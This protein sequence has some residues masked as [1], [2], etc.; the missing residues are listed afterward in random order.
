MRFSNVVKRIIESQR[1]MNRVIRDRTVDSWVKLSLTNAQL[2]SLF[3]ISR[4][5]KLNLSGLAA[6]I[7]VTPANV[8]GIADRLLEQ[9]LLTRTPDPTDRRV[10]WL[11]VTEAGETLLA[12]LREGRASEMRRILERLSD[13]ELLEVAGSFEI[14]AGAAEDSVRSG[15]D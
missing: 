3:Y 1:R 7:H 4:H 2:R 15:A 10:L 13:K 9:G 12:N 5:G 8:T 14:L 6:G 11:K